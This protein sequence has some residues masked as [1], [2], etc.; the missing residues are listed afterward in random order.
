MRLLS[1]IDDQA[2]TLQLEKARKGFNTMEEQVRVQGESITQLYWF[3]GDH[4]H[5]FRVVEKELNTMNKAVVEAQAEMSV[6]HD[7]C[8]Q[9]GILG[10]RNN[11]IDLSEED[12]VVKVRK[13]GPG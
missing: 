7:D 13:S 5:K 2:D 1:L 10:G 8:C 6:L 12:K 9:C 11:P 4:E 3:T